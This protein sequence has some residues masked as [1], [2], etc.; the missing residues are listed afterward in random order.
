MGR[1]NLRVIEVVGLLEELSDMRGGR[2][3]DV[4]V[5]VVGGD[6]FNFGSVEFKVSMEF[7]D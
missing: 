1:M 2:V 3:R 4:Q 6:K 7:P 5:L